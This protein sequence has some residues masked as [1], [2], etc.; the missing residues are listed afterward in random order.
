MFFALCAFAQEADYWAAGAEY[1]WYPTGH[2]L[3]VR[4][5]YGFAPHHA[6]DF[7][8]GINIINERDEGE[9]DLEEGSGFGFT[10]GYRYYLKSDNSGFFGSVRSDIWLNSIDWTDLDNGVVVATGTT[11]ITVVQPTLIA[12]Y[13]SQLGENWKFTP[14][15]GFGY[16]INVRTDGRDVG[17]GPITL[18]GLNITRRF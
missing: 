14:T 1:Q 10:P 8:A 18:F 5:E 3:G 13:A 12:G 9:Q 11:D 7:R 6:I 17:E 4:G 16:E 15:A 2:Q